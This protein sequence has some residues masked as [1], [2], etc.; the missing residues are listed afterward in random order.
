MQPI[1]RKFSDITV[2]S[3]IRATNYEDKKVQC[4]HGQLRSGCFA[5]LRCYRYL[6]AQPLQLLAVHNPQTI[7]HDLDEAF[8]L[9]IGERAV[10]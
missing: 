8:V 5:A 3:G 10:E 9:E 1:Y 7:V 6:P 2:N 4:Q